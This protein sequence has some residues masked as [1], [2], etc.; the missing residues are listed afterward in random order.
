MAKPKVTLTIPLLDPRLKE[1]IVRRAAAEDRSAASVCRT[2]LRQVL[3][4]ETSPR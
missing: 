4:P 1:A 3:L 2:I